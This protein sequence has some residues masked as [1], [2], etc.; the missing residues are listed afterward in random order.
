MAKMVRDLQNDKDF[1][2][3]VAL[4]KQ[5]WG[6][7]FTEI[8]PATMMRIAQKLGGIA[9]GA[10][11]NEQL[12][13]FVFGLTGLKDGAV[14]HWSDMLAVDT[15]HRNQGIGEELKRYQREQLLTRG[16]NRMFWTFD[17]LDSKNAHLNFNHLGVYAREY[18]V[19]MYGTTDS[20]LHATGTD[21]LVVTWDLDAPPRKQARATSHK[22]AIPLNI[23]ELDHAT[24]KQWR[25]R[26]REQFLRYLP[27]YVVTGFTK[28]D[29]AGYYT[30]TSAS[31]FTT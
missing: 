2:A 19:D 27:K 30:L 10:F 24:A 28:R 12:V 3:C 6:E 7:G 21:R 17:P 1:A 8:V 20:P 4:Q 18:V 22:I 16:I 31:N 29:N 5:T 26:T 23:H 15:E 25:E 9:A 13:G 11:E 14:I